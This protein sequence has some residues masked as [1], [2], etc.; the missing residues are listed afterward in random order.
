MMKTLKENLLQ[1]QHRMKF[2]ADLHRSERSLQVGDMA[3]LKI[4]PYR[5]NAFGLRGSLKL[6][7]KYYGPYKI[8]QKVGELAYNSLT[9]P[10]FIL[11]SM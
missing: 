1:A 11:F 6:R 2:F 7:S 5:Q 9:K 10:K 4:Q 8:I 3:Y